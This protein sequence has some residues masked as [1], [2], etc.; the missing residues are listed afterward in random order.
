MPHIRS[1]TICPGNSSVFEQN[2]PKPPEAKQK[3]RDFTVEIDGIDISVEELWFMEYHYIGKGTL[4]GAFLVGPHRMRVGTSVQNLGPGELRFGATTPVVR[5]FRGRIKAGIPDV[6]PEEHADTSFLELVTS[7]IE[8]H[9]DLLTLAPFSAY[10]G[11]IRLLDGTGSFDTLIK[12]AKGA[13]ADSS[14]LRY[15]T[16]KVGVRGEG[17]GVDSDWDLD[18]RVAKPEEEAELLPRIR[19][20]AK[21]TYVSAANRHGRISPCRSSATNRTS[22]CARCSSGA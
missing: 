15:T 5:Q 3:N 9:G 8:L 18:A 20:T 2:Q 10:T 6:N 14:Y 19:S 7:D 12:L 21:A 22:C 13:L 17:F 11:K 1:S 4:K 16:P